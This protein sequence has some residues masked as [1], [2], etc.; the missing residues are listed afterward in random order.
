M[1]CLQMRVCLCPSLPA[2][3][4][5]GRGCVGAWVRP[6]L[7]LGPASDDAFRPFSTMPLWPRHVARCPSRDHLVARVAW[8]VWHAVVWCAMGWG[9]MLWRGVA[10]RDMPWRGVAW[11][12]LM[13]AHLDIVRRWAERRVRHLHILG[14]QAI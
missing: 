5:V 1:P 6:Y 9:G 10:Y 14:I 3:A 2:D 8:V 11:R 13:S 4:C 7:A 12:V